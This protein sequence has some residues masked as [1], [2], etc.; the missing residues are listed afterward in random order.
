MNS[1]MDG[2]V[3]AGTPLGPLVLEPITR[4]TLAL[5]CGGSNDHYGIH[6]DSDYAKTVG[7]NDVIGHGMLSMAYVGRLLTSWAPQEQLRSL[8]TRFVDTTHPGDIPTL[9]GEVIEVVDIASEKCARVSLT[10][11]DQHGHTKITGEA[12]VAFSQRHVDSA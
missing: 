8:H 4:L 3:S 7:L 1:M 10:M 9:R 11:T 2:P 6:V 12:V 5:Y